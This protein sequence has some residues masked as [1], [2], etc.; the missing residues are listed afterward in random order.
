MRVG[1]PEK[2]VVEVVVVERTRGKTVTQRNEDEEPDDSEVRG[3]ENPRQDQRSAMD[4]DDRGRKKSR[5]NGNSDE[6]QY[7]YF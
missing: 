4:N 7:S 1:D 6:D 3:I 5:K 2:E